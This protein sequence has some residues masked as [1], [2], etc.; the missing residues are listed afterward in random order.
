MVYNQVAFGINDTFELTW[1]YSVTNNK[2]TEEKNQDK[3]I[4]KSQG[5]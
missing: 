1:N 3:K 4:A 2:E 5:V